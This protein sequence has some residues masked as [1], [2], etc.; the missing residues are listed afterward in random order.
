MRRAKHVLCGLAYAHSNSSRDFLQSSTVLTRSSPTTTVDNIIENVRNPTANTVPFDRAAIT[1]APRPP[2]LAVL[3]PERL[4]E[5]R[6][7]LSQFL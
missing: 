4:V 6:T 2:R 5:W 3:L 7:P 1:I